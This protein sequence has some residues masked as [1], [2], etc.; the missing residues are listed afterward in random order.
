MQSWNLATGEAYNPKGILSAVAD[1]LHNR[2]IGLL[3]GDIQPMLRDILLAFEIATYF[4][5]QQNQETNDPDELK[6]AP[7]GK[8]KETILIKDMSA[9]GHKF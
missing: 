9:K 3:Q 2:A 6:D 7:Q 4:N 1:L 5:S 8:L